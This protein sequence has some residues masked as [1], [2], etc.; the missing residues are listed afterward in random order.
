M[1]SLIYSCQANTAADTI[2]PQATVTH[3]SSNTADNILW[4]RYTTS[5]PSNLSA[6]LSRVTF[7]TDSTSSTLRRVVELAK[8]EVTATSAF[9]EKTLIIFTGR[10]R[11]VES[12]GQELAS[13]VS[14]LGISISAS[15]PKTLGD[16][17]TAL[18][19]SDVKAS[20]LILQA[21]PTGL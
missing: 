14:E 10:S 20:L 15:V 12:L 5:P 16:V 13:T 18:V 17:G 1:K 4:D 9:S 11:P 3:L 8:S 19:A 6:A 21:A 2:Y 7:R